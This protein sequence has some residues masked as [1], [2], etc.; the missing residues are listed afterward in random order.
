MVGVSGCASKPTDLK[1]NPNDKAMAQ[2]NSLL[3]DIKISNSQHK[4]SNSSDV[5]TQTG[6]QAVRGHGGQQNGRRDGK[7]KHW[8]KFDLASGHLVPQVKEQSSISGRKTYNGPSAN[9]FYLFPELP[10]EMR[11]KIWGY[12]ALHSRFIEI[13]WGPEFRNGYDLGGVVC[14][15]SDFRRRVS[16]AS[17]QPPAIFHVSREARDE[18]KK[19]YQLRTFDTKTPNH[20][21]RYIYYNPNCDIIYFGEESCISTMLFTFSAQPREPIPRVAITLSGKGSQKCNCD[22]DG[23]AYGADTDIR[24]MQALHGLFPPTIREEDK[25][26]WPGCL[27]LKEVFW[28]V[29]SSLWSVEQGNMSASVGMRHATTN[30]LTK[31]QQNLK[32]HL[33]WDMQYVEKGQWISGATNRWEADKDK[34]KFSFISFAPHPKYDGTTTT[35]RDG[36]GFSTPAIN[37]LL[38]N[39]CS[40]LKYVE[41]T[42]SARID[43][44]AQNYPGEDPREIGFTGTKEGIADAKKLI[45]DKL[46]TA[47]SD[48]VYVHRVSD[49]WEAWNHI[50]RLMPGQL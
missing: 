10:V 43:I 24:T 23:H 31:G 40:F 34:P 36:L 8:K 37:L 12:T 45:L 7:K 49:A 38:R 18:A 29:P 15:G 27:G 41:R 19:N 25:F 30:G 32:R 20:T 5:N 14:A 42:T 1:S 4:P 3:E 33:L 28:V 9:A 16:P 26:R 39:D 17:R 21:E 11:F 13:E 35:L 50:R 22:Y 46:S 6:T 48:K 44:P 47:K 2:L